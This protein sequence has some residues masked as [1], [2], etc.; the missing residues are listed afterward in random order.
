MSR[1]DN[2]EFGGVSRDPVARGVVKD[3]AHYLGEADGLYRE[4]KYDLALRSYSKVLE[5]NA[6]NHDAWTGQV[7]M[8]IEL[9]ELRE[10]KLWAD[11]A[12]E[13]FPTHPELLAAKAVSLARMADLDAALAFS[14]AA[15]EE[16]GNTPYVWLA[17]GDVLLAREET[18]A[19]YCFDQA[20]NLARAD[21]LHCWLASRIHSFHRSFALALRYAQQGTEAAP[22]RAVL[23]LQAGVCQLE[24]GQ[25]S[26]ARD[27]LEHARQLDPDCP[28]LELA[29]RNSEGTSWSGAL[30][31][32]ARGLFS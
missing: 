25:T 18:R 20:L 21:W 9:G 26:R 2:L 13:R 12:L 3:E 24:L 15:I 27:S 31:R 30:W 1:F 17:R 16:R 29:L 5:Y 32:R 23:W 4:G 11:K 7:R 8:L 19:S 6:A 22:D 28:G 10:A 14:D